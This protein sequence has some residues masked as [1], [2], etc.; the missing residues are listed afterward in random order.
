MAVGLLL[1]VAEPLSKRTVGKV[2]FDANNLNKKKQKLEKALMIVGN[3]QNGGLPAHGSK[4]WGWKP[5]TG[6]VG[7]LLPKAKYEK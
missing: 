4:A 1:F 7:V 5:L 6:Q 2:M 3:R